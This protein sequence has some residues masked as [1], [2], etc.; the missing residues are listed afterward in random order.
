MSF[1]RNPVFKGSISFKFLVDIKSNDLEDHERDKEFFRMNS[2]ILSFKR[3][4]SLVYLLGILALLVGLIFSVLSHFELCTTSCAEGHKYR[5]FGLKFEFFGMLFFTVALGGHLLSKKNSLFRTLT[6]LFLAAGVGSE[7]WFLYVQEMIIGKWCPLCL[8]I[9]SMVFVT[10]GLYFFRFIKE[11]FID[12]KQGAT[13]Q[14]I[15]KIFPSIGMMVIGFLIAFLGVAKINPLQAAQ[16]SLKD[17]ILFGNKSS[18]VE[19]YI[20]TDWFCPACKKV[21]SVLEKALPS[22]EP[23]AKIFF[24][25][26]GVHEQSLNFT[27]FNLSFM[28]HNKEKY[29]QLRQVLEELAKKTETPSDN[30]VEDAVKPLGIQV[31]EL[32][33]S[34]VALGVKLFKKLVKQFEI[35]R[36]PTVVIINLDTKKGKKLYGSSEITEANIHKAIDNLK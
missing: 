18:P 22:I 11:M 35:E 20:F 19:V 31:K 6:A 14:S 36:T 13:M 5:L 7:I 27:P 10:A 24:I 16:N 23:K 30:D 25:D 28:V 2:A 15:S 3:F 12:S 33:Y 26:A 32:N 8:T 29:F 21:E 9:A 1:G 17:N 4:D 34:D